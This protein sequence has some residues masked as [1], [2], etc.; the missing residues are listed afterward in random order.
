MLRSDFA[1]AFQAH[2]AATSPSAS[3]MSS[4]VPRASSGAEAFFRVAAP[5]R[6]AARRAPITVVS[7]IIRQ[8]RYGDSMKFRVC[9]LPST[10]TT[11]PSSPIFFAASP[12]NFTTSPCVSL[13]TVGMFFPTLGSF[14]VEFAISDTFASIPSP[15]IRMSHFP[16]NFPNSSI[17]AQVAKFSGV[18]QAGSNASLPACSQCVAASRVKD[19]KQLPLDQVVALGSLP[20]SLSTVVPLPVPLRPTRIMTH[21][22]SLGSLD[23]ISSAT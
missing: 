21:P 1:G 15:L 19:R 20:L 17:P 14:N 11:V 3:L 18:R 10:S 13:A 22:P 6:C 7:D 12:A 23:R 5:M 9:S 2:A 8:K 4:S 16:S